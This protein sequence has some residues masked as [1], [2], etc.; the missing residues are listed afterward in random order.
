MTASTIAILSFSVAFTGLMV[1]LISKL[2][3]VSVKYGE[4]VKHID[5]LQTQSKTA[6][7]E[8]SEDVV[9]I[10]RR[11]TEL[12]RKQTDTAI[13][14]ARIEENVQHLTQLCSKL[15]EKLDDICEKI[16]QK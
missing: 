11:V 10:D 4:I 8:T 6:Y 12:E 7:K 1:T 9:K 14:V 2:M 5:M 16:A 13:V 15:D 3:T